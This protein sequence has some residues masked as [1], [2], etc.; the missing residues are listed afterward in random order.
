MKKET[1]AKGNLQL[2]V[3]DFGP[4]A[5]AK[6]DLR[7]LTVFVGPSNTGKSYLAILIYAL[8]RFFVS[9]LSHRNWNGSIRLGQRILPEDVV[10]A[11]V[12]MLRSLPDNGEEAATDSIMVPPPIAAWLRSELHAT[13]Q[14]LAREVARCFG[15]GD[16][17][18]IIRRDGNKQPTAARVSLRWRIP[19]HGNFTN[20][21]VTFTGKEARLGNV[22]IPS[23][24]FPSCHPRELFKSFRNFVPVGWTGHSD[25]DRGIT[26]GLELNAWNTLDVLTDLVLSLL[27]GP[28]HWR[29]NYLPADR[30]GIMHTHSVVVSALIARASDPDPQPVDA[31]SGVVGDFLKQLV[32]IDLSRSSRQKSKLED[33]IKNIERNIFGGSVR[34]ERSA[35]INYPRFTYR[36]QGWDNDLAL[37]NAS[38]MV[39]ELAPVVLYLRHVIEPGNVLIIEE[40][41]AHLHPAMQV[42]FM[43]QLG[44]LVKA[45]VRVIVTTHSEWLVEELGNMVRRSQ[46][47]SNGHGD[48]IAL[49]PDQVGAWL[50]EPKQRP[51]GSVVRELKFGEYGLSDTG[52]DDVA[53]ALHND[54]TR[55]QRQIEGQP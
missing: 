17:A 43:R 21:E 45:G 34:V 14:D 52:F 41:E 42:Q 38:S 47:P 15:M 19:D 8:H 5:K 46:L 16:L 53:S 36:P 48:K 50:F 30:T 12:N 18:T 26:A 39:S 24:V 29:N 4:I 22:L 7:P 51:K 10:D 20:Y 40:P 11:V 25:L 3:A 31:L 23:H 55:I 32:D 2:E 33:T 1:V 49:R 44:A 27:A 6:V 9:G 28:M 13:S 37:A 54:W 35:H